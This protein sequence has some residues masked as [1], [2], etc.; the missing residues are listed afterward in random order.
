MSGRAGL[1]RKVGPVIRGTSDDDLA[2]L[3]DRRHDLGPARFVTA[4]EG[5]LLAEMA[6]RGLDPPPLPDLPEPQPSGLADRDAEIIAAVLAGE[7]AKAVAERFGLSAGHV[8]RLTAEARRSGATKPQRPS[9]HVVRD[10]PPLPEPD[11]APPRPLE[12]GPDGLPLSIPDDRVP[13]GEHDP[14]PDRPPPPALLGLLYHDRVNYLAG[15]KSTGKTWIGVEAL[16]VAVKQLAMRAVWLDAEDSAAVFSERLARLGHRDLTTSAFVRRLS[17]ADWID[18]EPG[19]RA[20]VAAWLADGGNGGHLFI[21]SGSA[22]GSG[23]SASDFAGWKL[24]HLVHDAV[25][26]VEHTAK[27]PEQRWGPAGSLRKAATATGAV[28]LIEGA[29][30]TAHHEGSIDVRLDKDRPG[31]IPY[32]KGELCA[33]IRGTPA[34]GLLI[35]EALPPGNPDEDIDAAILAA[36]EDQ[37]GITSTGIREAVG[38]DGKQVSRRLL[39]LVRNSDITRKPGARRAQH[40][41]IEDRDPIESDE[42]DSPRIPLGE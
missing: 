23:D 31:G 26:V 33:R 20:A 14:L 18:A 22:T 10:E 21:D 13:L 39:L 32:R 28:L 27:N 24:R 8:R 3:W 37:P 34:A 30:W 1:K 11:P 29:P 35:L 25:T 40:H 19:D 5:L 12:L 42:S 36:V 16:A 17:W 7:S 15:D 38:G 4:V 6:H 2:D 9:L 41:Y